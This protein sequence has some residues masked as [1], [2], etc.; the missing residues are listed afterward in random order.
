MSD[1]WAIVYAVNV[2]NQ[3][4][5]FFI[6]CLVV[7]IR[8]NR[9]SVV[10]LVP[11]RVNCIVNYY[12]ILKISVFYY[13]QI[14]NVYSFWGLDAVVTIQP[15]VNKFLGLLLLPDYLETLLLGWSLSDYYPFFLS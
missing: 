14:F 1:V 10:Q 7:I 15:M 13:P 12:Q 4:H 8:N 11:E 9:N 3:V 5:Q 2:V 6:I